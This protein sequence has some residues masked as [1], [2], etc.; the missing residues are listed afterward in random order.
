MT[1]EAKTAAVPKAPKAPREGGKAAAAAAGRILKGQPRGRQ[2][3]LRLTHVSVWSATKLSFFVCLALAVINVVAI[4]VLMTLIHAAGLFDTV[5]DFVAGI[6]GTSTVDV[7]ASFS[8]GTITGLAMLAGIVQIAFGTIFGALCA[9]VFNAIA[10]LIGGLRVS[11][12][13][14]K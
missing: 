11:F 10:A 5:N 9:F 1:S 4:F 12:T 6:V 8:T 7:G 3:S 13:N 2:V 14:D